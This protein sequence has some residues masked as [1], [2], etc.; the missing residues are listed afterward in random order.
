MV[1]VRLAHLDL[2]FLRT[3]HQ[4]NDVEF[5][6][7]NGS[8]SDVPLSAAQLQAYEF[9]KAWSGRVPLLHL[10]ARSG[11][12]KTTVLK[13]WQRETNGH[14][15][16]PSQLIQA[17]AKLHPFAIEEGVIQVLTEAIEKH[18]LVIIDDFDHF[19]RHAQTCGEYIRSNYFDTVLKVIAARSWDRR[20]SSRGAESNGMVASYP[21][22]RSGRLSLHSVSNDGSRIA[23]PRLQRDPS[24]CASHDLLATSA[25]FTLVVPPS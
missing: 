18:P 9:L 1:T 5:M 21:Q 3:G 24:V 23:P 17:V 16:D 12:G 8:S 22:F 4:T 14:W 7:T 19:Y 6:L 11:M 10:W 15:V 20:R 25:S 2:P 13:R